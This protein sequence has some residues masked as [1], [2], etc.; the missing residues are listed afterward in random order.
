VK[1]NTKSVDRAVRTYKIVEAAAE[2]GDNRYPIKG[3]ADRMKTVRMAIIVFDV[4]PR[5]L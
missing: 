4:I 5:H 2:W 1:I 3:M